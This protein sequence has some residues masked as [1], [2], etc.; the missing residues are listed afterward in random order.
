MDEPRR[1]GDGPRGGEGERSGLGVR[2]GLAAAVGL[3]ALASGL[4]LTRP[5]RRLVADVFGGRRRSPVESRV[6]DELW[7]D[8]LLGRRRIDVSEVEPGRVVLR[9]RV[10]SRD[11]VGRAMALAERAKGVK[12]VDDQLV[13]KG[14]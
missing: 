13:V 4:L 5:G 7:N 12:S 3:G 1:Y 10:R 9:G 14:A 2:L 6:L 11:E 8:R